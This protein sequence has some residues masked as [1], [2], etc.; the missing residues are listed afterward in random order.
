VIP[1]DPGEVLATL[2][3]HGVRFVV[4]GGIAGRTWGSPT[5]TRDLDVAYD[6]ADDNLERLAAALE[7]LDARLRIAGDADPDLPFQ[8]DVETLRRGLNFTFR[9]RAGDVDVLGQPAGVDGYAEL[10]PNAVAMT[11]GG[12]TVPVADLDD[13]IRMKLAAG[14]AKDRI[15]VEILA[16]VRDERERLG[17][18][19]P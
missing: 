17:R 5:V 12:V 6:R 4:I 2:E 10:I 11:I 14:R 19:D 1:F 9:T 15:E 3:Q 18:T 7:D 13:L 8:L 16:A